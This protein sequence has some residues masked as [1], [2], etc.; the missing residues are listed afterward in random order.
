MCAGDHPGGRGGDGVREVRRAA[1]RC[2]SSRRSARARARA[3]T[4]CIARRTSCATR[5]PAGFRVRLHEKDLEICRDM[6]ARHGVAV[7]ADRDDAGALPRLIDAGSRRRGHLDDLPPQGRAVRRRRRHGGRPAG[8]MSAQ[9]PVP[10]GDG[11][12]PRP[13]PA[14]LL[15]GARG[16]RRRADRRAAR[17]WCSRSRDSPLAARSGSISRAPRLFL[18]WIGLLCAGCCAGRD[19]GSRSRR[20]A[21]QR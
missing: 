17:R 11:R 4:S 16:A 20:R 1:A 3:G 10:T 5:Y 12:R 13:V 15:R 19:P 7:A 8:T 9:P 6:A 14:R 21:A 2:R 18:L